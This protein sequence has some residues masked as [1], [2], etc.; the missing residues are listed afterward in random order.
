M[1]LAATL[2]QHAALN[3]CDVNN[4]GKLYMMPLRLAPQCVRPA[5]CRLHITLARTARVRCLRK[6]GS[7]HP[8][9]HR[10]A[11]LRRQLNLAGPIASASDGKQVAH[12]AVRPFSQLGMW[13]A[14]DAAATIGSIVGA[15][16]FFI[17]SEA[18][19]AS[20][21][22]ILPLVAWYAGRQKEGLQVKASTALCCT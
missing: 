13:T 18:V 14:L 16:A 6:I 20:I 11:T 17:T 22:V 5:T 8:L 4:R 7:T 12:T 15:L 1:I 2:L 10:S 21:P 3:T 19:L 9:R